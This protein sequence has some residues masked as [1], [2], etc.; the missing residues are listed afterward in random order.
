M[1][2]RVVAFRVEKREKKPLWQRDEAITADGQCSRFGRPP[3]PL[4]MR[5]AL[6]DG[7]HAFSS[8]NIGRERVILIV[9]CILGHMNLYCSRVSCSA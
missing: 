1:I 9:A 5:L 4:C 2:W 6:C 8:C 3:T 7:K